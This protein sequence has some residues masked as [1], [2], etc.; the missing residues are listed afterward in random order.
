MPYLSG[1]DMS[2]VKA[3]YKSTYTLLLYFTLLV[4]G[5]VGGSL[6][7]QPSYWTP[8]VADASDARDEAAEGGVSATM[9][10]THC[11]TQPWTL[12]GRSSPCCDVT[13]T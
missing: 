4:G 10:L 12:S 2:H 6:V 7:R 1:L 13:V 9:L 5:Y 8:A 11:F 3:L